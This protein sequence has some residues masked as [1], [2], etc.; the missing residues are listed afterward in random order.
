MARLEHTFP[1]LFESYVLIKMFFSMSYC[2][3]LIACLWYLCGVTGGDRGW[4]VGVEETADT[5]S[6]TA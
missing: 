3:H 5:S 6:V 1:K 2:A 4:I